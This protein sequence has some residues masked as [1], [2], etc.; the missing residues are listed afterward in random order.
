MDGRF[1]TLEPLEPA[2]H[3]PSMAEG[4]D[5]QSTE[6]LSR[7]ETIASAADLERHL[8]ALN[9]LPKRLNWAVRFRQTGGVAGRISYSTVNPESGWVE[10]G[11]M[12]TAPFF[13]GPCNPEG[14]LLLMTRAF[15]VLG[16]TRVQFKVDSR[17][18]RS[19]AAMAKLGATRE[20]VLR[21]YQRRPDGF[22][23]DSVVFSVLASEWPQVK[24]GLEERLR[25]W[26]S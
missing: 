16:A 2:A 10:I 8:A 18:E 9:A 13:G 4:L 12:L 25:R 17:N 5:A 11:T 15:E 22:L 14:K 26:A 7:G 20:G 3:A 19:Q 23:R 24:A 6:F 21:K 1:V